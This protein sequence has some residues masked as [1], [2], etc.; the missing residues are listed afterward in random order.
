MIS[1]TFIFTLA[2]CATTAF[3][4]AKLD[5]VS[6]GKMSDA[7][8]YKLKS[9]ASIPGAKIAPDAKAAIDAEMQ[10]RVDAFNRA[11][12]VAAG[13]KN[14]AMDQARCVNKAPNL[15]N[16]SVQ[17][18]AEVGTWMPGADCVLR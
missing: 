4:T 3:A 5:S 17:Q 18:P 9:S 8:L 13:D 15:P 10:R 1:K 7:D 6:I 16:G 2:L 11:N 14:K 12:P